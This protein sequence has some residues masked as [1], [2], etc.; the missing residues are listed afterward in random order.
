MLLDV[1]MSEYLPGKIRQAATN[2]QRWNLYYQNTKNTA[3]YSKNLKK[4]FHCR[5]IL[6]TTT[7]S[8]WKQRKNWQPA[9]FTTQTKKNRK[10]F[11][12]TLKKSQKKLYQTF[13]IENNP[14]R[15]VYSEKKNGELKMCVYYKRINAVTIKIKYPLP[16][17]A[18]MKTK[19]K[20]ARYFTIL[21]LRNVF[22]FIRIK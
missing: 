17:M 21:D 6:K 20:D 9:L 22:N 14:T 16:L 7:K 1:K 19:F 8:F 5:N 10:F 12:F 2:L 11:R 18:D 4:V 13:E 15:Y 3:T